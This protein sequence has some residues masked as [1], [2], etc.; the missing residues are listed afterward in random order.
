M[1]N[2]LNAAREKLAIDILENFKG[3]ITGDYTDYIV[4]ENP[5]NRYF[6]PDS[7]YCFTCPRYCR[8]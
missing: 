6:V 3:K 8:L 5:E 7:F 4:G 1:S 2:A